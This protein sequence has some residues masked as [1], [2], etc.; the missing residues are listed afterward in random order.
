MG[1]GD[2]GSTP[3]TNGRIRR[4]DGTVT[5]GTSGHRPRWVAGLFSPPPPISSVTLLKARF[6]SRASSGLRAFT[7]RVL[8]LHGQDY[9]ADKLLHVAVPLVAV[10]GWLLVGPRGWISSRV[11]VLSTIYPALYFVWTLVHGVIVDWYPY[12]FADV[13]LHGYAVVILNGLGVV[14]LFGAFG[15]GALWLDGRL[16][17][18]A[19]NTARD[20]QSPAA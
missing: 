16:P 8:D 18:L 3:P 4:D 5:G 20:E 11:L 10:V 2:P 19:A 13:T 15:F 17:A 6:P 12:P 1:E 9:V 14:A 7:P